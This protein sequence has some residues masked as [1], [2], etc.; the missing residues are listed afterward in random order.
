MSRRTRRS[1]LPARLC[2][3]AALLSVAALSGG[4]IPALSADNGTIVGTVTANAPA[5]CIQLSAT[6]LDFGSVSFAANG[7]DSRAES[8]GV[9]VTNCSTAVSTV[10]IAGTDASGP[11]GA[12][13]LTD[14]WL[15]CDGRL[16]RYGLFTV[17][18]PERFSGD[19][20]VS[21]QR[22]LHHRRPPANDGVATF[23]P[24][25]SETFAFQV[26]MPCVGSVGSGATYSFSIGLTA[27]VT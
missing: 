8:S 24:T 5:P 18:L 20:L 3:S 7:S 4:A 23:D 19:Y 14:E 17:E 16:N 25:E 21:T 2:L 22:T 9:A 1:K 6:S 10:A 11:G 13:T 26:S 27:T 12:W 15:N